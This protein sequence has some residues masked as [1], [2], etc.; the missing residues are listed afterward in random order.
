VNQLVLI[1]TDGS[2][3]VLLATTPGVSGIALP[4]WTPDGNALVFEAATGGGSGQ[5]NIIDMMGTQRVL[6]HAPGDFSESVEP[7]FSSSTWALYFFGTVDS[8]GQSGVF[9]A[10]ADGSGSTFIFPGVQPAPSP[11]GSHV[12]YVSDTLLMVRDM[13]SGQVTVIAANPVLPRWSPKADL[14]AFV[15]FEPFQQVQIVRAD[16]S[17]LRT[18]TSGVSSFVVSWSPDGA[19]LA[20]AHWDGGLELIRVAD[21][22]QLPIPGTSHLTQPTWRPTQ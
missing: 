11:D 2:D 8:T 21:G 16:G 1:N 10:R 22:E 9:R 20:A 7:A 12:A 14:I 15:S 17:G 19:W 5:L 6:L 3:P 13:A 18:I 4:L